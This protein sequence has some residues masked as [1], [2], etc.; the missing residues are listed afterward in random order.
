MLG[1]DVVDLMDRDAQPE[2]FRARFDERV[3]AAC[4][5]RLIAQ[6]ED[7]HARRWVHWAAK[8]A[9]FK[10][11]KQVDADFIFAPSK[12]VAHFTDASS[13][14]GG[15]LERR[16]LLDL[17]NGPLAPGLD[18]LE[19]RSEETSEWIHVLALP[20]GGDW[21]AVRFAVERIREESGASDVVRRLAVDGVARELG[22]DRDRISI[23]RDRRIPTVEVDG[24]RISM[25]LSRS[26]HGNWVAC[27]TTLGDSSALQRGPGCA[28]EATRAGGWV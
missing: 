2:T 18:V 12:L 26:H 5:R 16:G 20:G 11:A 24:E 7:P 10:L 17:P 9:A 28:V 22:I 21:D 4:E 14:G 19:L 3:F 8:E 1:N 15:R 6:A 27:A 23:G 25:A 13:L